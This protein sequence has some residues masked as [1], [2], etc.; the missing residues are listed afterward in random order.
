MG[1]RSH[2]PGGP[3]AF[4]Q[5]L[6]RLGY[7]EG[8]NLFIEFRWAEGSRTG[9]REYAEELVRLRVDLIVAPSSIYTAAARQA[10]ATIPIVFMSHADPL[11]TGHVETL[12][13]PGGN[14]PPG[15][16]G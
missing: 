5:E 11:R 4:R 13:R 12:A 8:R 1:K 14:V 10:T 6:R 2:L 15:S 7:I 9:M 16:R 3:A